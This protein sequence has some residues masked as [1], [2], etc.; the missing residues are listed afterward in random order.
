MLTKS[1]YIITNKDDIKLILWDKD[2]KKEL[3]TI[4]HP[5]FKEY[6]FSL[7]KVQELG[8]VHHFVLKHDKNISI[9]TYNISSKVHTVSTIASNVY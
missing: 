4:T 1:I 5:S 3:A 2:S 8:D 9:V 7:K 6:F